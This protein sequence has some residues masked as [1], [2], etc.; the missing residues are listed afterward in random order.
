MFYEEGVGELRLS[1][2]GLGNAIGFY[3][4]RAA[5]RREDHADDFEREGPIGPLR[6]AKPC[7]RV[8]TTKGH[9]EARSP[10]A[11]YD[12]ND[13]QCNAL[14][15]H[16]L[17]T[18]NVTEH[19]F[20]STSIRMSGDGMGGLKVQLLLFQLAFDASVMCTPDCPANL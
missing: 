3:P 9:E 13:Y 6:A 5:K 7:G 14:G 10:A 4:R 20:Y 15:N 18:R 8:F 16:W 19:I 11:S 12:S 17:P 2:R 1:D